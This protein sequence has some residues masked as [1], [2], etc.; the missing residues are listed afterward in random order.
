MRL[1]SLMI[2]ILLIGVCVLSGCGQ[3]QVADDTNIP[4]PKIE[5][6]VSEE[7]PTAKSPLPIQTD[8]NLRTDIGFDKDN[9][10][11][12]E[13][14]ERYDYVANSAYGL[15]VVGQKQPPHEEYGEAMDLYALLDSNG[16]EIL[17]CKY[18][19]INIVAEDMI[20]VGFMDEI[21]YDY[22]LGPVFPGKFGAFDFAGK[23]TIPFEYMFIEIIDG[24]IY[25][26]QNSYYIDE[27]GNDIVSNLAE[28]QSVAVS[29]FLATPTMFDNSVQLLGGP[30]MRSEY[31][32]YDKLG[33]RLQ[34]GE[35]M[36]VEYCA[37]N[38]M[39][40]VREYN[41]EG[42][43][44]YFVTDKNAAPVNDRQYDIFSR[45][46]NN[47]Y[48]V[49]Y[50]GLFGLYDENLERIVEPIYKNINPWRD[51]ISP[52]A[53]GYYLFETDTGKGIWDKDL[54]III[55]PLYSRLSY[56]G[57]LNY[58]GISTPEG[59][60][61]GYL[62]SSGNVVI[63]LM[64]DFAHP[65]FSNDE[66]AKVRIGTQA[67][68]Y[69]LQG[70]RTEPPL[71]DRWHRL[72]ADD[73][74]I[75]IRNEAGQIWNFGEGFEIANVLNYPSY[76]L[77]DNR[78]GKG[79]M[80]K[81]GAL[82]YDYSMIT[83]PIFNDFI[84]FSVTPNRQIAIVG[85]YPRMRKPTIPYVHVPIIRDYGVLSRNGALIIPLKY[86]RIR[87]VDS[88]TVVT[89]N[90][91]VYSLLRFN[92]YAKPDNFSS[93]IALMSGYEEIQIQHISEWDVPLINAKLDG[94]WGIYNA[95]GVCLIQPEYDSLFYSES[96]I[97]V[98]IGRQIGI[99]L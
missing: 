92:E 79:M 19:G 9:I 96:V 60:K 5:S 95:D 67:Y 44:R 78:E 32:F 72:T 63:P 81:Y 86:N 69:D 22:W 16:N 39:M 51:G 29:N 91:D 28:T 10:Q 64:Y 62:D 66:F 34:I 53:E 52:I 74:T 48:R 23:Q 61:F 59:E 85:T 33:N 93:P 21:V 42:E 55:E 54:N 76:S 37:P 99:H 46:R 94:H 12:F 83:P 80:A 40:V 70:N 26:A 38:R 18:L 1:T 77:I 13:L 57:E 43:M 15:I 82:G 84:D 49:R 47:N 56:F 27:D 71:E 6:H 35:G 30:P 3:T 41:A 45:D 98:V 68:W 24:T 75:I 73:G 8:R 31:H 58:A 89:E 20:I 14:D 36:H 11:W 2:A 88:S 7:A 97:V 4:F 25:H 65:L 17:E 87:V 90:D 50:N